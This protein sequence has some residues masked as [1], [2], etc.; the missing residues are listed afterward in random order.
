MEIPG[1]LESPLANQWDAGKIA[2]TWLQTGYDVATRKA[3]IERLAKSGIPPEVLAQAVQMADHAVGARTSA[4]K[5][6]QAAAIAGQD[7]QFR[8]KLAGKV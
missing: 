1:L 2:Q 3:H 6:Q 8:A 4:V 7:Q 5:Q